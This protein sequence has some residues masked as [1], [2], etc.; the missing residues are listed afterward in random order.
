MGFD[1]KILAVGQKRDVMEGAGE[2]VGRVLPAWSRWI[3]F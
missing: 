1:R 3:L 2:I